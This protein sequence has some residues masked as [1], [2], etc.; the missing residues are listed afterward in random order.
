MQVLL[1]PTVGERL[2]RIVVAGTLALSMGAG[3]VA[4]PHQA[5]AAQNGTVT[6]EATDA[7]MQPNS[8]KVYQVFV[9]QGGIDKTDKATRLV[10]NDALKK[11]VLAYLNANGYAQW[12]SSNGHV[13]K[14]A[15]ELPQN[16]AEFISERIK[17]GP[18][19]PAGQKAFPTPIGSSFATGL[20][21]ALESQS[22]TVATY[23]AGD[24]FTNYEG[25]YLFV[26]NESSVKADEAGTA[27]IWVPLGGSTDG[28]SISEKTAIPTLSKEVKEDSSGT[29]GP[30]ADANMGQDLEYRLTGTV[31]DNIAA[32][33]SYHCKFVDTLPAGMELSGAS[34]SSVVVKV[35]DVDVTSDVANP[36]GS[37]AYS[38]NVLT[39]DI[40]DL[41][42]LRDGLSVSKGT[43][44]TVLYKAHLT[45]EGVIGA[46]GNQNTAKM[47]YPKDPVSLKMSDPAK[48]DEGTT[49]KT[50]NTY[51]YRLTLNKVDKQTA[52]PLKGA[53]FTVQIAEK[54]S[55]AVSKGKYVDEKG[56]I[57]AKA[58]TFTTDGKGMFEVPRIDEG[59][60]IIH[61]TEAPEGYETSPDMTVTVA[62]ELNETTGRLDK[63]SATVTGGEGASGKG[64]STDVVTHLDG[65]PDVKSGL[66]K[67]QTPNDKKVEMPVTGM[68]GIAAAT[69]FGGG[70]VALGLM[71]WFVARRKACALDGGESDASEADRG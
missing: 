53:K 21:Q 68:D 43:T 54:N 13:A 40:N 16:A 24:T 39:V 35:G 19:D 36:K 71:G 51:T 57:V 18:F 11:P 3:V 42:S 14:G 32:Y 61:E 2:G 15:S 48:A 8:Y 60:Y 31:P 6:I 9:A 29:W 38:G 10:W 69:M 12:L 62:S 20:A 50:T 66:V 46:D 47:Y 17:A 37:I 26:S 67:V 30:A 63:L 5:L 41:L 34:T 25:Y 7:N 70:A 58:H 49:G 33:K 1:R 55:D 59:T 22:P 44:V 64:T 52:E 65:A 56:Q 4:M 27:P 23:T 45:A 28:T